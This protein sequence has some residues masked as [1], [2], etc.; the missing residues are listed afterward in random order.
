M[1][2]REEDRQRDTEAMR[3][4]YFVH[5]VNDPAV[6]RRIAMLRI[7]GIDVTLTGF[8]R[9][10]SPNNI[11]DWDVFPLSRT[12]DGRLLHRARTTLRHA[13]RAGKIAE[14]FEGTDVF[15]ARNLE[16]LAIAVATARHMR[17][18]PAIVYEVLDIHRTLLSAA[19][20][21]MVLRSVERVL[22]QN[23]ALLVTS[24]P[25]FL[26]NFFQVHQFGDRA[27]P[28]LIIENKLFP[29]TPRHA[30]AAQIL[31]ARPWRI[32]W[33]GVIRCRR[34]LRI[35]GELARRRPD[36]VQLEIRGRIA[37]NVRE[38]LETQL[39]RTPAVTF[40]GAYAPEELP[41]LYAGVHFS[42]TIDYFEEGGNSEWLLPNR[43]Y[44]GGSFDAVPLARARTETGRWLADNRLGM[45]FDQPVV[46]LEL[47][48]QTLSPERYVA[49]RH[50]CSRAPRSLFMATEKDCFRLAAALNHACSKACAADDA[51]RA[52]A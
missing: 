40:G 43:L 28:A 36:L 8:W 37:D 9:G 4:V 21:G 14:Q 45:L 25:A 5:D 51:M 32:G 3:L 19:P 17:R 30:P 7:G 41:E 29:A 27:V 35:L 20:S 6:A 16:M 18:R 11:G 24:S 22:M 38:E 1:E 50:A 52:A 48:L 47:F 12:F 23:A 33:F 15:L 34:S 2:A 39:R 31:P 10:A 46:E 13:S 26:A 42:W 49:L 44:E